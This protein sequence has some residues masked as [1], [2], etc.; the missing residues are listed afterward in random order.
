MQD[1]DL[2]DTTMDGKPFKAGRHAAT[3]RRTLWREHLG[4]LPPQDN[5]GSNDPNA[6]PPGDGPNKILGGV[7]DKLVTDPMADPL[8][9]MWTEQATTNTDTYRYLFRADPD[10]NIKTFEDYDN[11]APRANV[12]QGHLQDPFMPAKE[13]KEKLDQIKGH[14]VWMPL[15]FLKDA[16]MA[17]KGLSVNQFTEVSFPALLIVLVYPPSTH[18]F[19]W[20]SFEAN[21]VLP[22]RV[23]TRKNSSLDSYGDF[24]IK[25]YVHTFFR[26]CFWI[27]ARLE[28]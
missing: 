20:L 16:E 18:R 4:L 27:Y 12:K 7:E 3:L 17:E 9:N 28:K 23:S 21:P 22:C 8:W 19:P 5:D 1:T 24:H 11:F 14:L 2:I 6:Q 13:V 15:D 25:V 26:I 10:D